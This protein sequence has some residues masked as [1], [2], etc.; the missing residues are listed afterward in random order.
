MDKGEKQNM[1]TKEFQI[2]II[3]TPADNQIPLL[4]ATKKILSLF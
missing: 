4:F 2:W 1:K 3:V